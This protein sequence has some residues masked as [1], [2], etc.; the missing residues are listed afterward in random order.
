VEYRLRRR[1]GARRLRPGV[2]RAGDLLNLGFDD[3]LEQEIARGGIDLE[4]QGDGDPRVELLAALESGI[5][6]RR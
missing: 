2:A 5:G 6:D 1:C 4:S 3:G